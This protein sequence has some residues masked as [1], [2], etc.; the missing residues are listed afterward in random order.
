MTANGYH[1]ALRT[2]SGCTVTAIT[3]LGF[4]LSGCTGPGTDNGSQTANPRSN[5]FAGCFA[6]G[7]TTGNTGCGLLNSL[8]IRTQMR[9]LRRR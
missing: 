3:L 5:L 6:P 8:A 4:L 1:H 9:R 2:M 7:G